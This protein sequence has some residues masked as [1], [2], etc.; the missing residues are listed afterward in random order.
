MNDKRYTENSKLEA[1][2]VFSRG[3]SPSYLAGK[4]FR[5]HKLAV[6]GLGVTVVL[7]LLASFAP[8]VSRYPP[9]HVNLMAKELPPNAQYWLGT[10]QTG[11]DV[12]SRI[13]Y[14]SRVSLIVGFG[15]ASLVV[16]IGTVLGSLAGYFGGVV[17]NIISR[18]TDVFMCFPTLVIIIILVA[19]L[20]PG[21]QNTI[22]V[23]GLFWWPSLCRLVRSQVLS[24]RERDYVMA[25]QAL[26]ATSGRIIFRH[27][28]PNAVG[29]ILIQSTFLVTGAILT[30]ASL[31][32]LGLGV[33]IPVASWGSMLFYSRELRILAGFPWL[34]MPPGIMI[35]ITAI[36]IN[37][38]GDALRDA[39]D[40][41]TVI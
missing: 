7:I 36:S 5:R 39:L 30:E 3:L 27:I 25:S 35:F 38:I 26:S 13:I 1:P 10:D 15:S 11:R 16:A 41:R 21:L 17:D 37:F 29:P 40:P 8:F 6:V 20:G 18:L 12:W 22:L 9:N 28:L 31:S 14:G 19:L 33:Q 24:L 23:I 4:R 32:F 2:G 34:W